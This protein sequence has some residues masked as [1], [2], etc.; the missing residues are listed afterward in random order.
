ME[1]DFDLERVFKAI[2]DKNCEKVGLQFPE[3][4]KRQ[5]IEIA[6]E[7]EEK[8]CARV[9]ISGNPSFG[10]C[11]VD[12]ALTGKVDM[13][14]HFGHAAMG[15]YKNVVF[16]EARS[17]VDVIPVVKA[18]LPILKTNRIGIVTTV[19]HIHKLE[20]VSELLKENGKEVVIG[21]GDSRLQYPGQV[22]GC[23]FTAARVDCE[24]F[25][26]VGSGF[27]H[28]IGVAIATRKRVIA[29]DPY[30]NQA[31]EV[32]PERFLRKRSGYIASSMSAKVFGIIV[33]TKSGQS[34][35][36]IAERLVESAKKHKREAFIIMMDLVTPE[37]LLA[38][39]LDACVNTACPRIT[40]DDAERFHVPVLTPQE[41]EMMLGER[42][43]DFEMDEI[44]GA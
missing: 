20:E 35:I 11:D 36:N 23:N 17:S 41:F 13:L 42:K 43:W 18:A 15:I 39:K 6:R 2:K 21:K 38:F 14:F 34:R 9:I 8:T 29:A 25:L 10:A 27:F 33:S 44:L 40:I 12:I 26:Y 7:I 30:L 37:Q 24:E 32:S 16:I 1:F 5:A 3:G 22:I 19:Q 31:V 28:P 4:L